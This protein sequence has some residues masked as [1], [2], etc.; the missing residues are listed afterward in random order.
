MIKIYVIVRN[1]LSVLGLINQHC[2]QVYRWERHRPLT[3]GG[4]LHLFAWR[5][6]SVSRSSAHTSAWRTGSALA[7]RS[8]ASRAKPGGP[9]QLSSAGL[10]LHRNTGVKTFRAERSEALPHSSQNGDGKVGRSTPPGPH[11]PAQAGYSCPICD[12]TGKP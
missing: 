6:S 12:L 3:S 2:R 4:I 9:A 5:T 8:S 7:S 10:R 1:A 11:E